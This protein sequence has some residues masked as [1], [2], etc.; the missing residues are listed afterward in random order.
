MGALTS[1]I[2]GMASGETAAIVRRARWAAI[3][4]A[5]AGIAALCGIGFLVGAGYI[6]AA[7]HYGSLP[8]ALGFGIGFLVLAGLIVLIFRLSAGLRARKRAKQRRTDMTAIGVTA[9][10]AVLPS[11]LRGKSGLGLLLAPAVALAAY[12]IYKENGGPDKNGR[13][14]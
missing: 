3:A 14:D 9:A 4:Y 2:A 7:R 12:A 11:L 1:L 6:W 10:L 5:I 13:P 8:A